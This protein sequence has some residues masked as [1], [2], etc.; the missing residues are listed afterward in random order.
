MCKVPGQA[1]PLEQ[2]SALLYSVIAESELNDQMRAEGGCDLSTAFSEMKATLVIADLT[3]PLLAA[4]EAN[5][6]F[7]LLVEQFRTQSLPEHSG[8]LLM[9][10]ECHKYMEGSKADGLSNAIVNC[11]RLMR[12]DGSR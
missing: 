11:A 1:A 4:D 9:L 5:A 10:D 6:I 8:K 12:H 3:D 2:R 7:Q